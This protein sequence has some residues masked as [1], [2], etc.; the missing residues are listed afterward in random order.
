MKLRLLFGMLCMTQAIVAQQPETK[1]KSYF[2]IVREAYPIPPRVKRLVRKDLVFPKVG[3]YQV[4][5]GD[6]HLHTIFSGGSVLP[7]ERIYEAYSDGL[8]V[9]AIT[10]HAEYMKTH[11]CPKQ[12][13]GELTVRTA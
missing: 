5:T 7:S 10:D 6:F 12:F 13:F 3:E 11:S 8:D 1:G 9:L 4:V 2:D